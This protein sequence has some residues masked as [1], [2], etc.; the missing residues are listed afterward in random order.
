VVGC[1]TCFWY[2]LK[3]IYKCSLYGRD[4]ELILFY[5]C[6]CLYHPAPGTGWNKYCIPVK[7]C[8]YG[9]NC[10]LISFYICRWMYHISA[11]SVRC[12]ADWDKCCL[13]RENY[14]LISFYIFRWLYHTAAGACSWHAGGAGWD[15]QVLP[16]WRKL[17]TNPI[18]HRKKLRNFYVYQVTTFLD[19]LVRKK[20]HC[21]LRTFYILSTE[22][23]MK[24]DTN[25]KFNLALFI[26][27]KNLK[28]T[29][30]KQDAVDE[31]QQTGCIY[32]STLSSL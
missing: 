18:S 12:H 5:I 14:E 16:L 3:Y 4:C 31:M 21:K 29:I 10:E 24:T 23:I 9:G 22:F 32:W 30:T 8:L 7:C 28:F 17:W 6:R 13:Y 11:V 2:W 25:L 19:L 26:L 27:F 20:I 1:I 15:I